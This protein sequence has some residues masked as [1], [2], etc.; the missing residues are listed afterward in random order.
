MKRLK[1]KLEKKLENLTILFFD[2]FEECA[3]SIEGPEIIAKNF[4]YSLKIK[5]SH[6]D[7]SEYKSINII[8]HPSPGG[9]RYNLGSLVVGKSVPSSL[10]NIRIIQNI[11]EDF[12]NMLEE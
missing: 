5:F 12:K 8:S 6:Y 3:C 10:S 1:G 2:K 7:G 4:A 9:L 11:I